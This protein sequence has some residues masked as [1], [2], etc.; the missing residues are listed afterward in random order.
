MLNRH[1]LRCPQD[2]LDSQIGP[3][4]SQ[5]GRLDRTYAILIRPDCLKIRCRHARLLQRLTVGILKGC[6]A[7]GAAHLVATFEKQRRERGLCVEKHDQSTGAQ[8]R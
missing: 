1:Q 4:K 6:R 2:P 8:R 7:E 5:R 3:L